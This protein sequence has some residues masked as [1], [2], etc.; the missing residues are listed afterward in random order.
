MM[1]ENSASGLSLFDLLARHWSLESNIVQTAFNHDDSGVVF[2]LGSGKL[3][4]ASTKDSESPKNR[5][6]MEVDTGRTMIRPREK[7]VTPLKVP[8]I[9]LCPGL[10]VVRF[11]AQ[12]FAAV[13]QAGALQ[14]VTVGG[15]VVLKLKAEADSVTSLC[16]SVSGGVLAL[17]RQ[18]R[19][20]MYD[21]AEMDLLA[22][23][24][25]AHPVTCS[26]I[27]QNET[28]LAAWGNGKLSLID[29]RAPSA[30]AQ[31]INCAGDIS[32]I[33]WRKSGSHLCCA[34][35]DKSVQIV[36]CATGTAQ[37][38]E[39]FPSQVRN[40]AFSNA[41]NALVASGAFRLVGWDGDDLPQDDMPGTPLT[42]G[43]AGF[44]VINALAAHPERGLVA[45]GYANGLVAIASIGSTEEMMLHQEK[46][47]EVTGLGWSTTGE[48]LAIGFASGKAAIV[49]FPVQMFK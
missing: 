9:S 46:A 3:A 2:R 43:K 36:D 13:D 48:H 41:S 28:T 25:A 23:V 12:G 16:S 42:I 49:T 34:S 11:A 33:S 21:T 39:G 40:T 45:T 32:E 15:Q 14:Q 18:D 19:I 44:V 20:L 17:A 1:V 31:V 27:S 7:P 22:E 38:V 6:R 26:A 35:A 47:T 4:L 24:V 37:R 30:A 29:L 8:K 5:T 10:P